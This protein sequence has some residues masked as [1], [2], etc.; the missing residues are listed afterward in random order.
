M[1]KI[2]ISFLALLL[3]SISYAVEIKVSGQGKAPLTGYNIGATRDNEDVYMNKKALNSK[4]EFLHTQQIK[5]ASRQAEKRKKEDKRMGN[6]VRMAVVSLA[7][8]KAEKNAINLLIDRV[9]G[10]NA[11][12]KADVKEKFNDLYSQNG[13]YILDRTYSG[14][15]IDNFYVAK[16]EL[17]VDET[18]F[19]TLISDL[20]IALNT[21]KVRQSGILIVL[22]EFFTNPSDMSGNTV[23]KEITIYDYKYNEK[24]KEK[25][26]ASYKDSG[27]TLANTS[28]GNYYGAG[29]ASASLKSNTS[30]N[31][32]N[33]IDY[34]QD[35]S[36]FYQ[37]IKEYT[38]KSPTAENLNYTQPALVNA[39]STYDIRPIDNDV[40]KSKFFK[41]QYVTSDKLSNSEVLA[42]YVNYAK[43]SAK[44]DFFAIGVSYITDNGR[45]Q[46]TG[47]YTCDGNVFVKIYSTQ[48]GELIAAG[49]YTETGSG[50]SPDQARA[51]VAGKVGNELGS[52]LSKKIQDY[53]KRRIMYGSEYVIQIKGDFLPVER[54]TINKAM[55]NVDGIK[56][57][58][59][60]TSDSTQAEFTVN[61]LG[62][63]DVADAIFMKLYESNLS[64]KFQN[65]DY[66]IS[67]NQIIFSPISKKET[68]NL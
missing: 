16:V 11:S 10:A 31:Y 64:N 43:T 35:E 45:N 6:A 49:S 56:N 37:H 58:K 19:R 22:D 9:L 62:Q 32:G 30:A 36:E 60:R 38:P 59:L 18:E 44:A 4:T 1:K 17:T 13:V 33:F 50:N 23:T 25:E 7:Q 54:I 47:K 51:M 41:G 53:W 42:N 8:E 12:Q 26:S 29:G 57:V 63:D 61:Y 21:E 65:Y 67:G 24:N 48:D 3:G 15:V 40:F 2:F 28:Y 46:N 68:P 52:V 34:A 5:E 20:G 66:K 27:N 39:F 14:E 55:Q